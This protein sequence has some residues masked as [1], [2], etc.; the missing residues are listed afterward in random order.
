MPTAEQN[1]DQVR[2]T[3]AERQPGYA[4]ALDQAAALA[5]AEPEPEAEAS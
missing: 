5:A 4:A 3:L 1:R 2:A